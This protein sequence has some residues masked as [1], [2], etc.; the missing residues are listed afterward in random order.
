MALSS[1]Q[2]NT[3]RAQRNASDRGRQERI[4]QNA[5]S[6]GRTPYFESQSRPAA[7]V[8]DHYEFESESARQPQERPSGWDWTRIFEKLHELDQKFP[9]ETLKVC[10][11]KNEFERSVREGIPSIGFKSRAVV[12]STAGRN[13]TKFHVTCFA[14]IPGIGS[15]GR[16][17]GRGSAVRHAPRKVILSPMSMSGS[18]GDRQAQDAATHAEMSRSMAKAGRDALRRA[19][20][21]AE[22]DVR[23]RIGAKVAAELRLEKAKAAVATRASDQGFET[24][25]NTLGWMWSAI[26]MIAVGVFFALH[27]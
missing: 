25:G 8:E 16:W 13:F 5:A 1:D 10:D 21:I 3:R 26:V 7:A 11:S 24:T 4:T 17:I 14:F 9:F 6:H 19:E 15:T 22:D 23:R 20:R 18:T 27:F 2:I 12:G